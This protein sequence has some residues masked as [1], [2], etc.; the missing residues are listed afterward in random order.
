MFA[1]AQEPNLGF[2]DNLVADLT[3]LV[4]NLIPFVVALALLFFFWGVF[5]FFI[6]G[7][8]DEGKRETGRA[9]MVYGLIGL[10]AIVAVWGLV[11][12]IITILGVNP[13][14]PVAVPEIPR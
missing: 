11:Q 10:V 1:L 12:L 7:A 13:N 4:N 6:L 5:Q 14:A 3:N 2:F 9:Y 8:G